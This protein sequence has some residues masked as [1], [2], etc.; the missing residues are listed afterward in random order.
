MFAFGA[1]FRMMMLRC[2]HA[3]LYLYRWFALQM[4]HFSL[5]YMDKHMYH[6]Q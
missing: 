4:L 3:D 2:L 6:C 1:G 5:Q